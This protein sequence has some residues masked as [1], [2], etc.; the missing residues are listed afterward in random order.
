[1]AATGE[2]PVDSRRRA[3]DLPEGGERQLIQ[4]L[5]G[6]EVP[7]GGLPR[8]IGVVVQNVATARAAS[9][10]V[11]LGEPWSNASSR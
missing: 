6:R 8:D 2:G 4:V 5:T 1:M 9:R 7:R 3:H 11:A 10:A